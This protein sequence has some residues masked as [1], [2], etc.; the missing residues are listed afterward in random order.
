MLKETERKDKMQSRAQ[1][2]VG[3]G[4]S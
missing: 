4:T 2:I 3:M 1:R